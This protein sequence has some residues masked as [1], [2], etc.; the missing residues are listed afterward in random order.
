LQ[1]TNPTEIGE[2]PIAPPLPPRLPF[3]MSVAGVL[4]CAATPATAISINCRVE[5]FVKKKFV[6]G[7][8]T[9][10]ESAQAHETLPK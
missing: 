7:G 1:P 3:N 9:G 2:I 5:S 8:L 4:R 10:L 6:T